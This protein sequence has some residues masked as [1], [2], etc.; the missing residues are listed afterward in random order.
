M[1]VSDDNK[2]ITARTSGAVLRRVVRLR[3]N[4]S[5]QTVVLA[6][7]L[8]LVRCVVELEASLT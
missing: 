6:V 3:M 8:T 7:V 5:G 1:G 2:K 4:G